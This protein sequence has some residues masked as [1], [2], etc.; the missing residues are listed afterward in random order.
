MIIILTGLVVLIGPSGICQCHQGLTIPLAARPQQERAGRNRWTLGLC[1]GFLDGSGRLL[2]CPNMV[3]DHA[4][5]CQAGL[6]S[7]KT[8]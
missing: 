6:V 7:I 5:I 4:E 2:R 8:G 3:R 1:V